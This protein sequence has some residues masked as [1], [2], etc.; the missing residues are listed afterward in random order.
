MSMLYVRAR[1]AAIPFFLLV[2]CFL[3]RLLYAYVRYVGTSFAN[4]CRVENYLLIF[5]TL[6]IKPCRRKKKNHNNTAVAAAA[7]EGRQTDIN[8][9]SSFHF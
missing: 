4:I 7:V 1:A 9:G 2:T 6:S 5:I 3:T 8:T